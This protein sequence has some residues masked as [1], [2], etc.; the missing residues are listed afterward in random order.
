MIKRFADF[1]KKKKKIVF[2]RLSINDNKLYVLRWLFNHCNHV[3][4]YQKKK[5]INETIIR[6]SYS[7]SKLL[8]LIFRVGSRNFRGRR[9]SI[10]FRFL[11]GIPRVGTQVGGT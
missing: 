1:E 8:S 10:S 7:K 3:L 4:K 5:I 2:A 11:T 6:F 9:R